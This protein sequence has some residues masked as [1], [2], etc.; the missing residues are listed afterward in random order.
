MGPL[1]ALWA[2]WLALKA[3]IKAKWLWSVD[4][5]C[6]GDGKPSHPK[7][8]TWAVLLCFAT[9]HPIPSTVV[10]CLVT[11]SFGLKAYLMFLQHNTSTETST[12]SRVDT[13]TVVETKTLIEQVQARRDP[14]DGIE[15][16]E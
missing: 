6:S 2:R 5:L 3:D 12:D 9:S 4:F 15:S 11:A 7:L 1:K 13:H 8:V 16:A 14:S 10:V